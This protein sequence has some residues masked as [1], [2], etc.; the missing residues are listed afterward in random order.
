MK[1]F[2]KS[3]NV[4]SGFGQAIHKHSLT[5]RS[6]LPG[7][8][9]SAS[10]SRWTVAEVLPSIVKR[11][12]EVLM[13]GLVLGLFLYVIWGSLNLP[14]VM[15][16]NANGKCVKVESPSPHHTCQ[17]LPERYEAVWVR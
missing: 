8:S 9:H 13:A 2:S 15:Y 3:S 1:N 10:A 14:L 5:P 7:L 16:S 11:L 4:F 12:V 6:S 17:N